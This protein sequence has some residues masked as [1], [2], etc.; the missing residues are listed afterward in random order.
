M[1]KSQYFQL[2]AFGALVSGCSSMRQ[3]PVPLSSAITQTATELAIAADALEHPERHPE[4]VSRL[5]EEQRRWLAIVR[6]SYDAGKV[7][8][9]YTVTRDDHGNISVSF[10]PYAG[11]GLGGGIVAV[12]TQ[13]W[14]N[15]PVERNDEA[16]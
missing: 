12:Q 10:P 15:F 9:T 11:L 16:F 2:L 3:S 8:V 5:N 7:T 14:S 13:L 6:K 4:L 1:N